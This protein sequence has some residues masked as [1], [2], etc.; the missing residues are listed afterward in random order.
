M[1]R[2]ADLTDD[3]LLEQM[4]AYNKR[5]DFSCEEREVLDRISKKSTLTSHDVAL[6]GWLIE[7]AQEMEEADL[8]LPHQSRRLC[9]LGKQYASL[10]RRVLAR[11]QGGD[12]VL[13]DKD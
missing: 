10:K 2:F 1:D 3:E 11:M 9:A 5:T 13:C 12:L 8:D 6:V 4:T 7:K